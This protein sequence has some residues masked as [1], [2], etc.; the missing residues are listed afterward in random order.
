MD[1]RNGSPPALRFAEELLVFLLDKQSGR[2]TPVPDRTRYY[3]LA[4][5]ILMDLA[6]E[7]RVDTDLERLVVTDS[8]RLN[9]DLLDPALAMIAADPDVHDTAHWIEHLSS[10]EIAGEVQENAIARLIERRI[11]EQDASGGLSLTRLVGR[12]RRYPMVNGGA[13]REVEA[14]IMGILFADDVPDPRDAMLI[15]VVDACGIF[16]R[17]LS[18]EERAEVADRIDLLRSLDL[19]GRTVSDAIRGL[20]VPG[21]DDGPEHGAII[22]GPE[23]RAAALAKIPMPDGG[24]PILGHGIGLSTDPMAFLVKQY[25]ALGP[26]FRVRVPGEA[27]TFLAG[28][29]VNAFLQRHS[30]LYLR[31][32]EAMAPMV[33]RLRA[34]RTLLNMDG[35]EHYRLRRAINKSYSQ[36]V[37]LNR[38][39]TVADVATRRVSD[40]PEDKPLTVLAALRPILAEQ[41]ARVITGT[42]VFDRFDD[43]SYYV[44]TVVAYQSRRVPKWVLGLPRAQ[45]SRAVTCR[46]A[47][48]MLNTHD[49]QHRA[50][51][52][53]DLI[54]ALVELHRTD[55]QFLPQN[56]LRVGS[57]APLLAGLH[58]TAPT[59][60]F[61][62][63]E[64][65][66]H[67]EIHA[68]MQAEADVFFG[69]EGPTPDKLRAMDVTRR[70][71]METLRLYPVAGLIP[72][73]V[74]NTFEVAGHTIPYGEQIIVAATV[75]H[76]CPEHY[77]DPLSWDIDRF[78]PE[79][80]EHRPRGVYAPF[81]LGAHRCIGEGFAEVQITLTVATILHLA[82][83]T[84]HSPRGKLK[85]KYD[86]ALTPGKAFKINVA[87]RH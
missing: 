70:A 51:A 62:L 64:V 68:A 54:D 30:R 49:P 80:S 28:P 71:L 34:H 47:E 10:P 1:M 42:T 43:F 12:A 22:P 53:P 6:L 14:R 38:L 11:L 15:A 5:T 59:A 63:F 73:D 74:V 58:T 69:G 83:V 21:S 72:R 77:P 78:L 50:G 55:P 25:R 41:A 44:D 36:Q 24:L 32:F 18:A 35:Q 40:W 33:R 65:L 3:A 56:E 23:E 7:D 16:D 8:T 85:P 4:G 81:G 39:D 79:R 52:D 67:P 9:D 2:L 13:G 26:V 31:S 82:D 57:I 45:R 19:I 86:P 17:I 75:P 29:E 48:E 87:R 46:L 61:M 20:A 27:L 60:A 66:R 84:R 37:A 76:L